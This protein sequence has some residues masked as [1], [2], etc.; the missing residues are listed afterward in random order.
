[1]SLI[2]K[3]DPHAFVLV[4]GLLLTSCATTGPGG[5]KSLILISD[6]Q[7]VGIGKS[8]DAEVRKQYKPL[9]DSAWQAY[10]AEVGEKIVKVCDRPNLEYHFTVIESDQINAFAT[11]GGYVFFYT[12]ILRMMDNEAEMAAVMAH[13]ISHV[14]G[15]HSVKHL[16]LAYGGA[17][18]LQL[19]LGNQANKVAGDIVSSVM[20]LALT[21]YGRSHELEADKFGVFY[22]QKAGYNPNAAKTM[23]EKLSQ[24]SAGGKQG[25]FESL[26]ATHPDTQERISRVDAEIA[27]LPRSVDKLPINESRYKAMKKRLPPPAPDS[28]GVNK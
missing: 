7:E 22:M 6:E 24:L 26:S 14:V 17:L 13:E 15:R 16:Q 12:G 23:F 20:G 4:F 25:F 11:P 10:L 27:G 18:G 2:R 5:Q 1:M 19:V 9:P 28:T 21:G 8:V 3:L